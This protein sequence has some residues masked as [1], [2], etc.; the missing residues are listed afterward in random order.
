MEK[1]HTLSSNKSENEQI[2]DGGSNL[3]DY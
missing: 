3:N 1:G 2:F